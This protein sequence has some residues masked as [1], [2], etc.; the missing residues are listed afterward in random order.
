MEE[1]WQYDADELVTYI[2]KYES[3]VEA[4]KNRNMGIVFF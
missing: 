1:L 2:H 3:Y 4:L